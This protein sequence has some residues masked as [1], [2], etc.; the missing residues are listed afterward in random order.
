M[1]RQG[2]SA[3]EI[4]AYKKRVVLDDRWQRTDLVFH[5]NNIRVPIYNA[6][7]WYDLF[8]FGSVN[9]FQYLQDDGHADARGKQQL[10]MGN[11]HD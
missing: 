3:E 1:R 2:V 7:G 6:G 11:N 8:S 4:N 5:R 9:N 10:M